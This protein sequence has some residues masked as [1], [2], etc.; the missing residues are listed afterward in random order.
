[1]IYSK[2]VRNQFDCYRTLNWWAIHRSSVIALA[3]SNHS[4]ICVRACLLLFFVFVFF[5][6][7]DDFLFVEYS[8]YLTISWFRNGWFYIDMN[9]SKRKLIDFFFFVCEIERKKKHFSR[10]V[11]LR[12]C[13]IITNQFRM[14]WIFVFLSVC[15]AL[16]QIIGILTT[17]YHLGHNN[18]C[19]TFEPFLWKPI[20]SIVVDGKERI[21]ASYICNVFHCVSYSNLCFLLNF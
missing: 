8:F 17:I 21:V 2:M 11:L 5:L 19:K 20:F 14:W 6:A 13:K 9:D 1:M 10:F 3:N 18:V 7:V 12:I 15:F 4:W 16:S